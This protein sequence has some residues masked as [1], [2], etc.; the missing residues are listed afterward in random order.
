MNIIKKKMLDR[1]MR[2]ICSEVNELIKSQPPVEFTKE[3]FEESK[4]K[5]YDSAYERLTE[6]KVRF[7]YQEKIEDISKRYSAELDKYWDEEIQV[8]KVSRYQLD[9][10]TDK[11]VYVKGDKKFIL[12]KDDEMADEDF[13]TYMVYLYR[14]NKILAPFSLETEMQL[15]EMNG[16]LM[17]L[18]HM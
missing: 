14:L 17:Q 7:T 8:Y 3:F 6:P 5:A 1:E 16:K 4:Q 2:K 13:E 10:I 12:K 9:A 11:L 18:P 15:K